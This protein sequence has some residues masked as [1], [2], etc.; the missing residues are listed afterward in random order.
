[1]T[2]VV[3]T[4]AYRHS[5]VLPC[6]VIRKQGEEPPSGPCSCQGS[7]GAKGNSQAAGQSRAR[8]CPGVHAGCDGGSGRRTEGQER[9]GALSGGDTGGDRSPRGTLGTQASSSGEQVTGA[10]GEGSQAKHGHRMPC[11][12]MVGVFRTF[13]T[14]FSSCR[15]AARLTEHRHLLPVGWKRLLSPLGRASLPSLMGDSF[16]ALTGQHLPARGQ[17]L[18]GQHNPFSWRPWPWGCISHAHPVLN[19]R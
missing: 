8:L 18:R 12:R 4:L 7:P 11:E 14:L 15:H 16:L 13:L 19:V 6:A 10:A 3:C 9:P 5:G 2:P 17:C 1:M